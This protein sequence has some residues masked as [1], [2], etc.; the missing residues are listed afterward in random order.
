M[1]LKVG[2]KVR[3]TKH[4]AWCGLVGETCVVSNIESPDSEF[5]CRIKHKSNWDCLMFEKEI[6]KYIVGEQ[7]LLFE[8]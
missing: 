2:D 7:L 6:E 3:I 4:A 8:L 1:N 5:I